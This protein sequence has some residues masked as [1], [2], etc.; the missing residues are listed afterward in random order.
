[1][2]TASNSVEKRERHYIAM[3]VRFVVIMLHS[4]GLLA[5]DDTAYYRHRHLY[6]RNAVT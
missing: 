3:K 4:S 1:M 6:Q 5:D 2:C